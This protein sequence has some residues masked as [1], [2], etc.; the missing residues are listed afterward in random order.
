[1]NA[2]NGKP[3]VYNEFINKLVLPVSTDMVKLMQQFVTKFFADFQM[4]KDPTMVPPVSHLTPLTPAEQEEEE[5][6][7]WSSRIWSFLDHLH[8][9]MR[10]LPVWKHETPA[11]FDVSKAHCE[12]FLYIKLYPVLFASDVEDVMLNERTKERIESLAFLTTEHLDIK[13]LK[14]LYEMYLKKKTDEE[15]RSARRPSGSGISNSSNNNGGS[16]NSNSVVSAA[17][18][19]SAAAGG[20]A[21]RLQMDDD[22]FL[23][24]LLQP[25]MQ[26][27][28]DM[29]E[30][31]CPQDKLL[32][33]KRCTMS[34]A[35][36]LK[37]C[38]KD[39][40]LPGADEL[41]P[42]MIFAIKCCNPQQLQSNVKYLQRY[43]R[44]SQLIA[45]AGY[46]LTQFVSAVN[47]LEGVDG[48]AL[49]IEPEEFDRAALQSKMKAKAANDRALQLQQ[50]SLNRAKDKEKEEKEKGSSSSSSRS[51]NN[52]AADFGDSVRDIEA[53]I[54]QLL[55]EYKKAINH[56]NK[57]EF[58]TARE[59]YQNRTATKTGPASLA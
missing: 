47:F 49:C 43:T 10:A 4:E 14:P 12:K 38:R 6:Q 23:E 34:I 53:D 58:V 1:V 15:N 48:K 18:S 21:E 41:L 33:I 30:A 22:R 56:N 46:L 24:E 37:N 3:D 57:L 20:G 52:S 59:V 36:L 44:S 29:G 13:G 54:S 9:T 27:L 28:R 16:G 8:E 39:G 40:T 19:G 50:R 26:F 55:A 17:G 31:K 25:S 2:S 35:V 42:M 5:F 7:T 11:N 51:R 45:E 32:C